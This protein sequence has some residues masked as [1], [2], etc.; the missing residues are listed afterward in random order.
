MALNLFRYPA[1]N[2]SF[3]PAIRAGTIVE[4]DGSG[5]LVF[6]DL[7]VDRSGAAVAGFIFYRLYCDQA[8]LHMILVPIV[9]D[10][11]TES[12]FQDGICF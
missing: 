12:I 5:K 10:W 7:R 1:I 9:Q 8:L 11:L 6:S 4:L 3:Q 2:L